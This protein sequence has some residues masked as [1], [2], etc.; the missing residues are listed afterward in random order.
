MVRDV[1][2]SDG[3]IRLG[4]LLKLANLVS[5]GSDARPLLASG[6][7]S[8][9]GD[10]ETRRGRRLHPGDVV[11]LAGVQV[12]VASGDA[13]PGRGP[14]RQ[15]ARPPAGHRPALFELGD[16]GPM[17]D[18]LVAAVQRGEKTATSSL[19][20]FYTIQGLPLPRSGDRSLMVGSGGEPLGTIELTDAAVIR[21]GDVG[22]D[23][24]VA[25][26]ERFADAAE[27]RSAHE[28]YWGGFADEVRARLGNPDWSLDDDTPVVVEWFRLA[29][30]DEPSA[31]AGGPATRAIG[32]DESV[33]GG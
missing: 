21:L 14:G 16:P 17:R 11:A 9:N 19:E 10:L 5:S 32:P 6:S 20:V 33:A 18:R 7:V 24:A 4:Q 25:E 22:D 27:W 29:P 8:V 3:E 12:R 1:T 28:H 2:I 23:I 13:S 26:G 15:R 30:P 31:D